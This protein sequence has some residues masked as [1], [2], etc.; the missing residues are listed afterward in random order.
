MPIDGKFFL[1]YLKEIG[2]NDLAGCQQLKGKLSNIVHPDTKS[3]K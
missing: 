1:A 2:M 3:N